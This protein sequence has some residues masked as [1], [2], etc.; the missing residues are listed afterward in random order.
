VIGSSNLNAPSNANTTERL[1][2]VEANNDAA[3]GDN[4]AVDDKVTEL[5]CTSTVEVAPVELELLSDSNSTDGESTIGGLSLSGSKGTSVSS[6]FMD[7]SN[8][9]FNPVGG[10]L[11]LGWLSRTHPIISYD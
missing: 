10:C 2:K 8:L 9:H 6:L 4:A 7:G 11:G 3:V 5:R 1:S